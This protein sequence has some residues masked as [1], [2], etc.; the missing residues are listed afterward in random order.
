MDIEKVFQQTL[1]NMKEICLMIKDMDLDNIYGM[2]KMFIKE[3]GRI[4]KE[5][6]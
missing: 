1:I 6:V 4:I 3:N 2:T 5:M